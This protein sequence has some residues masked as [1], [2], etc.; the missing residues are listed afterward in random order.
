MFFS[1]KG[2]TSVF[3]VFLRGKAKNTAKWKNPAAAK[4]TRRQKKRII[5]KDYAIFAAERRKSGQNGEKL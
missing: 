2:E 5:K 1:E 4:L 3:F